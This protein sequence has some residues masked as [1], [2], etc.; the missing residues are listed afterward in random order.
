MALSLVRLNP[1][2]ILENLLINLTLG[3]LIPTGVNTAAMVSTLI[4]KSSQ[5]RCIPFVRFK[6]RTVLNNAFLMKMALQDRA[7]NMAQNMICIVRSIGYVENYMLSIGILSDH[8]G[9][10]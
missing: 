7:G 1:S 9:K 3:S 4:L 2:R 8:S 6:K 10:K 5:S